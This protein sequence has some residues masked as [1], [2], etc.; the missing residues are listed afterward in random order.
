M[1]DVAATG[2]DAPAQAPDAGL[3]ARRRR[4][5]RPTYVAQAASYLFDLTV[6]VPYSLLGVTDP[7]LAV[8]YV[9]LGLVTVGIFAGLSELQVNDRFRDH[10]L[11][12]PQSLANITVL[13]A[14]MAVM[15][16]IGF[17]F[18]CIIFIVLSFATLR[19]SPWQGAGIC[20]YA[21]AGAAVVL[22]S[23]DHVVG[24]PNVT[25]AERGLALLCFCSTLVRFCITGLFGASLRIQFY[26]RSNEL[27][28][29][30]RRIE[31]MARVDEL[32]GALSR[33]TVMA[34]LQGEA[35]EVATG[36]QV[37]VALIDLD[38]FKRVNDRFG[39]PAGDEA[40]RTFAINIAANL[41]EADHFGRYGGEEFLLV[42]PELSLAE[43]EVMLE[44][45]RQ[46]VACLNWAAIAPGLT[47]TISCGLTQVTAGEG[48]DT[49]LARV[50]Q[51]LYRAKAAGRNCIVAVGLPALVAPPLQPAAGS[52]VSE[53]AA[54]LA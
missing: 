30:N 41:R 17:Y 8:A 38:F 34:A 12:V 18:V 11:A 40:L 46:T 27:A 23:G 43:A 50:D 52:E 10:Y 14:A 32:T 6:L 47:L 51:A 1:T 39:H 36:R 33:R 16:A 19:I 15:P 42:L 5:R 26:R 48:A 20:A 28:E 7:A 24:L 22:L 37:C 45:L 54:T 2:R 9:A 21:T 4:K 44:R 31:E 25:L 13:L 29:A 49:V 53:T 35:A 3:L